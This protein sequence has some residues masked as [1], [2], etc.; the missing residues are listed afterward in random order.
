MNS[1]PTAMRVEAFAGRDVANTPDER[2]LD[3]QGGPGTVRGHTLT[4]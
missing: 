1:R 3:S 2:V 4:L